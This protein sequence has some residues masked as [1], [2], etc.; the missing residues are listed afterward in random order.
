[1]VIVFTRA[2]NWL[3]W[4]SMGPMVPD[5]RLRVTQVRYNLAMLLVPT[6]LAQSPI[7]GLGLFAAAPI[8]EGTIV[9][10]YN[11]LFDRTIWVGEAAEMPAVARSYLERYAYRRGDRLVLCGDDGRFVN[12]ADAPNCVEAFDGC[13]VAARD[14]AAGE[15]I[16]E[17]YSAYD[18]DTPT[19][20]G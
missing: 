17:D 12:H 9:W 11:V 14:I 20:I 8:A 18:D 2:A 13:S 5:L 10:R 19:K 1:M 3:V 16:T 6:Y 7:H 15:E 4:G